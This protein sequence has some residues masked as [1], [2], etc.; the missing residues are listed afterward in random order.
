MAEETA[1]SIERLIPPL[2]VTVN[3][4]G[5]YTGT[6]FADLLIAGTLGYVAVAAGLALLD[7]VHYDWDTNEAG[8]HWYHWVFWPVALIY[9]QIAYSVVR[10][11]YTSLADELPAE[12]SRWQRIAMDSLS[13]GLGRMY[14]DMI[15]NLN[16]LKERYQDPASR[17]AV[18]QQV[19]AALALAQQRTCHKDQ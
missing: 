11:A 2:D 19:Q 10:R 1:A 17:Q 6:T 14:C 8:K 4:S 15:T 3:V 13:P 12:C 7:L 16:R 9:R 18:Q 5:G